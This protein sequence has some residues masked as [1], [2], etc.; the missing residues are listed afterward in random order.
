MRSVHLSGRNPELNWAPCRVTH[1]RNGVHGVQHVLL[2]FAERPVATG[3]EL[4]VAAAG[5]R[6]LVCAGRRQD[7]NRSDEDVGAV[8]T[9]GTA[10][11]E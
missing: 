8:P 6:D 1:P 3:I 2:H 5:A 11:S 10:E 9:V 7:L 4:L